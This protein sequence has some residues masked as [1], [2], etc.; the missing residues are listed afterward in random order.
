RVGIRDDFFVLGG[1][2]L[3]AT[4]VLSRMRQV[5]GSELALSDFFAAPRIA[6]LAARIEGAERAQSP[7]TR[8]AHKGPLPLSFAQQRLWFLHQLE[9]ENPEYHMPAAVAVDGP[10]E[11]A[12]LRRSLDEIV[13]RHETLRTRFGEE[14][15]NPVQIIDPP[16]P[17]ALPLID[18]TALPA[19][20]RERELRRLSAA[21]AVRLFD[22][23]RGPL[24]RTTLVRLGRERHVFLFNQHH[25]ISDG[26]SLGIFIRE[27][28][29]R[30][31]PLPVR[32][33][34]FAV[35]QRQYLGGEVLE[36]QLDYWRRRLAGAA[37]LELPADRPRPAV[38]SGRGKTLSFTL[39]GALHEDLEAL[40]RRCGATLFMTLLAAFQALLH[41]Y[42][43]Q[44]DVVVGTPVAGRRWAEVEDLIGF[45][46]N[47]LVQRA[48]L[49][50]EPAFAELVERVRGHALEAFSHQDVPFE[51]LVEEL[52]PRRDRSRT[53]LFQ[54]MFVLQNAAVEPLELEGLVLRP[55]PTDS[56]TSKVDLTLT[57]APGRAG[58]IEYAVELFDGATIARLAR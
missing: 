47:T 57:L 27:L 21:E 30:R 37:P 38:R 1:H 6:E 8:V 48:D 36:R 3:L 5:F 26:W 39:P 24:L 45:F 22:L 29:G 9:P 18:L 25:V 19:A 34:D 55:L 28:S 13:R 41:R 56:G 35:W 46:V 42:T 11:V 49:T 20:W 58:S 14:G 32:Y 52:Q 2:S 51:R 43:G 23:R 10:L 31:P 17:Q 16:R 15:E 50:G 53:P 44:R 33:A 7:I 12:V 54:V 40:S 4:R